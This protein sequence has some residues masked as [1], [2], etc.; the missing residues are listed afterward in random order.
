MSSP[1]ACFHLSHLFV[2]LTFVLCKSAVGLVQR[3]L[4][5]KHVLLVF[6]ALDDDLLDGAFLLSQDLDGLRMISLLRVQFEFDVTHARF[7]FGDG[8]TSSNDSI[9]FDLF[10]TDWKILWKGNAVNKWKP[11]WTRLMTHLDFNFQRLLDGFDLDNTFLFIVK[12][13]DSVFKLH[14]TWKMFCR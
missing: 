13:F 10:E 11:S 8:T 4:Q 2:Q 3:F 9:S 1:Y 6:F 12:N 5:Q 7:Q 14:L